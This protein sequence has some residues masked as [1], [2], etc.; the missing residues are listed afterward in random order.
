MNRIDKFE[1]ELVQVKSAVAEIGGKQA[2]IEKSVES[3]RE[4]AFNNGCRIKDV[5][6]ILDKQEQ[7]NKKSSVRL[8][9]VEEETEENV[10][11]KCIAVIKEQIG[12]DIAK[13]EIDIIHRVGRVQG[14]QNGKPR[15]ILVKFVSHKSKENIM[16]RKR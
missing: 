2:E 1:E 14:R 11:E 5:D 3:A 15:Q 9:N 16:R 6:F 7:Y 12:V 4:E 10:E 8:L 13:T